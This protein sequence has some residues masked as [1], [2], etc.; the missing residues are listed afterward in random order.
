[1]TMQHNTRKEEEYHRRVLEYEKQ[2]AEYDKQAEAFN[3]QAEAF[4]VSLQEYHDQEKRLEAWQEFQDRVDVSII[5][6]THNY[7]HVFTRLLD[8]FSVGTTGV[9]YELIVVDNGSE[10][11]SVEILKQYLKAKRIHKL[12]LEP[13]NHWFSEG[14]NIGVRHSDPRSKYILLLNSDVEILDPHWLL[15]LTEWMEGIPR[16][17]LAHTWATHPTNPS[18]GPRDIV[19]MGWSYAEYVPGLARPEG[20]CYMIRRTWWKDISPDFPFYHG[21]EEMTAD[22]LH[23]GAKAGVLFNYSRYVRHYEGGCE[24]WKRKDEIINKRSPAEDKWFAGAP[25]VETLDF[26]LGPYEHQ[27]YMEW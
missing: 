2:A 14:N 11:E 9:P 13:I 25:P 15:R 4:D 19:T 3:K 7:P 22:R 23:H 10:P 24:S 18:L 16:T 5:V 12:V 1:M 21:L 26:T 27:S 20:W 8:S 6:L 17:Y